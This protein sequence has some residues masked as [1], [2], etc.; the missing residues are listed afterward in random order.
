[1]EWRRLMRTP[2]A[3]FTLA[4]ATLLLSWRFL[5]ALESFSGLQNN[6]SG[7]GLSHHL[8]LQL[9]GQATVILLLITPILAMRAVSESFRSGAFTL[10][11][12]APL[13]MPTVLLGKWFGIVM[14]QLLLVLL[15]TGMCLSLA[16][17]AH[18]DPGLIAAATL[19]LLLLSLL[20]GAATLYLALLS[21]N[22]AFTA[23]AG[24]GLLLLLS[25]LDQHTPGGSFLH[26]LAWPTHYLNLQ[27]GL[28]HTGDLA[29]FLLLTLF[30]LGLGLHRLDRRRRG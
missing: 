18:L 21:E 11:S 30:F 29:Y 4:M 8:G 10:L 19:G 20:F 9:Y 23:A 12:S 28:V 26:W 24:Y 22:P 14:F 7:P 1:M 6:A 16:G 13:S 2:F 25:L 27:L 17:A 3:W 15:P 5:G